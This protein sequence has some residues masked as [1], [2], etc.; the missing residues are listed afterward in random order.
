MLIDRQT[1]IQTH[2]QTLLKNSTLSASYVG[3]NEPISLLCH[4]IIKYHSALNTSTHHYTDYQCT[5]HI[6]GC[7]GV[8]AL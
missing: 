3:S 4:I 7:S 6:N 1:D 5:Q 2:K 8:D